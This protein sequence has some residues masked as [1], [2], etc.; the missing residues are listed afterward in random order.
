MH[1]ICYFRLS[2]LSLGSSHFSDVSW[3]RRANSPIFYDFFELLGFRSNGNPNSPTKI[4]VGTIIHPNSSTCLCSDYPL[5][6]IISEYWDVGVTGI[7]LFRQKKMS[8]YWDVG[9]LGI[10]FVR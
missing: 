6:Q 9:I 1:L 2:L 10:P 3:V 8:N 4:I 5:I 7:P